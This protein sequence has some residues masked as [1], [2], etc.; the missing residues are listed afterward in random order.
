QHLLER[1]QLLAAPRAQHRHFA[2]L[3][4]GGRRGHTQGH[5]QHQRRS[6][7]TMSFQHDCVLLSNIDR[8]NVDRP[9]ASPAA[10]RRGGRL[11]HKLPCAFR[12]PRFARFHCRGLHFF[13]AT[14]CAF[15]LSRLALFHCDGLRVSTATVRTF[16][17]SPRELPAS[18]SLRR[19]HPL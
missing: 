16:T 4:E 13:S 3:R 19:H 7:P 15:P 14:V 9:R 2:R 10:L 17:T 5:G 11:H 12:L 1:L 18:R 8:P 6:E